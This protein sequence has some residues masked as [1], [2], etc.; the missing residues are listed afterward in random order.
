MKGAMPLHTGPAAR[1]AAGVAAVKNQAPVGLETE[2]GGDDKYAPLPP[3][4]TTQYAVI[5]LW[6]FCIDKRCA[7]IS[8]PEYL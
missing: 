6:M 7:L 1:L 3:S 8:R 5:D 4:G 2:D